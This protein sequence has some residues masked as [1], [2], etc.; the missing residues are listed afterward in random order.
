MK[1]VS[2]KDEDWSIEFCS[3]KLTEYFMAKINTVHT[4]NFL[5]KHNSGQDINTRHILCGKR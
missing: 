3:Y 5:M 4:K 2:R 1:H